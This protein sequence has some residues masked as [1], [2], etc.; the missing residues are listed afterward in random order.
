VSLS[1]AV[2][3]EEMHSRL[4]PQLGDD[5]ELV[6]WHP[7]DSPLPRMIDLLVMPYTVTH[8][9]LASLG[10]QVRYIQAQSLGYDR[11]EGFVPDGV[12]Y[13]N[14]VGVHEAPT[15]EM[16]MTLILASQRGW[17]EVGRNQDAEI[18]GRTM[19]PGLIGQ[20][21]LLIGVGGIGGE[22]EKRIT[23]F[24]VELTRVA[25]TARADIHG[26]DELPSLLPEADIVVVAIPLNAETEGLIDGAF[27]DRLPHGALLVNVSRGPIVDT[28]ALV[29]HVRT[30]A[31]R[32]A[33]DVVDP[34]PLPVGHPLWS[35][36]GSLIAPHL[37]GAVQSMNSRIDPLVL[38]Q[39]DRLLRGERPLHIVID[40]G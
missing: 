29:E 13:S 17:P 39:I 6:V 2:P 21:V 22:F 11:A 15:A 35:L 14:A 34:E 37:G 7:G 3:D 12:V 28:D 40:K 33:L 8:D 23:G 4:A 27:L 16:A 32:A 10:G 18:W 1:V 36:P 24:G 20:R 26:I 19:W 25:R 31:V 9:A 5:V 38:D 30:G